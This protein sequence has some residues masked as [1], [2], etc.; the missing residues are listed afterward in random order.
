M[1]E[2]I[3]AITKHM[4]QKWTV[5][6]DWKEVAEGSRLNSDPYYGEECAIHI[7]GI[8]IAYAEAMGMLFKLERKLRSQIRANINNEV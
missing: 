3:E 1:L 8:H 5:F 6:N 4:S 2:D 7:E